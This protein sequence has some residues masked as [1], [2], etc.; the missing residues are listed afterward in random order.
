M[1]TLLRA[2]GLYMVRV[3][4][5]LHAC[6]SKK[7]ASVAS[8]FLQVSKHAFCMVSKVCLRWASI[9]EKTETEIRV[10]MHRKQEASKQ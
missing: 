10:H 3:Y 2:K 7:S 4:A 9:W 8:K 5:S 1:P 6:V